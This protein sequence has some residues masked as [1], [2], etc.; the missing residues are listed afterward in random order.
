MF[1]EMLEPINVCKRNADETL[2]VIST[3]KLLIELDLETMK[4]STHYV[5][6]RYQVEGTFDFQ[7]IVV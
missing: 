3:K 2:T 4:L 1:Q 6:R 5:G 7:Y